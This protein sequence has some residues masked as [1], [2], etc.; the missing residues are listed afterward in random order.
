MSSETNNPP[1]D[2]E[3]SE[4]EMS[5]STAE[6]SALDDLE[7]VQPEDA[8]R[9]KSIFSSSA[10]QEEQR[11]PADS[12]SSEPSE[13]SESSMLT[14]GI[15]V[16]VILGLLAFWLRADWQNGC[17]SE[18]IKNRDF[19]NAE[20]W[21]GWS[22]F[23]HPGN[24]EAEFLKAR[25]LRLQGD[26][27]A[28]M[29][30]LEVAKDAGLDPKRAERERTLAL[31][32]LGQVNQVQDQLGDLL[33]NPGDD[34]HEICEAFVMGYITTR[35]FR[36]AET[37]ADAWAKDFPEDAQPH[38]YVGVIHRENGR[39]EAAQ[40]EL[41]RAVALDPEHSAAARELGE[42]LVIRKIPAEALKYFQM[43]QK[44]E[45]S[46]ML[47]GLVGEV[48]CLRALGRSD[49]ARER[50]QAAMGIDP[51]DSAV[52]FEAAQVEMDE[53]QYDA[54]I[55]VLEPAVEANPRDHNLRNAYAEALGGVGRT[56]EAKEQFDHVDAFKN[57]LREAKVLVEELT[58]NPDDPDKRYRIGKL[59]LDYGDPKEGLIWLYGIFN[60]TRGHLPTH[61]ALADYYEA[62]KDQSPRFAELA[63]AHKLMSEGRFM[64]LMPQEGMP[65]GMMPGGMPGGMPQGAIPQGGIPAGQ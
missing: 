59:H 65:Q 48:Q 1:S 33:Q 58:S 28:S 18:A 20:W 25:I 39:W 22:E 47:A 55:V 8:T 50:I 11:L 27:Q 54:A 46:Q 34:A 63:R 14:K 13:P 49:E 15:V 56:D 62:N 57:K 45:D 44:Q 17:A 4:V 3:P 60:Y 43:S 29:D 7:E 38:Y 23:V 31:A 2:D 42:V 32:Y 52:A 35:T 37:I 6:D 51:L 36:Q 9:P 40:A 53:N 26:F 10:S 21:I 16:L 5:E 61:K 12:E 24:L 41:E 30:Q 19:E 64:E